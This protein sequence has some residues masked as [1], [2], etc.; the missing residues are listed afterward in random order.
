V[1]GQSSP[2]K[3]DQYANK[4]AEMWGE[5]RDWLRGDSQIPDDPGLRDGL[6]GRE[7][8][9]NARNAIQLEKKEDMKAR[10]L[11]SPDEADALA[12]T[13]AEPVRAHRLIQLPE[14]VAINRGGVRNS[15]RHSGLRRDLDWR[16]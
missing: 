2:N 16:L 11:V 5:M 4:S 13:F 3:K 14:G 9:H 7:Y 1:L 12:L 8:G 6:I 15:R 10:G